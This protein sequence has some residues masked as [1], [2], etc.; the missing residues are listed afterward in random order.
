MTTPRTARANSA[1]Q[2]TQAD[3]LRET[4]IAE[5]G[6]LKAIRSDRVAAAFRAV[7]RGSTRP[8]TVTG[9]VDGRDHPLSA[10]RHRAVRA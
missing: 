9:T 10:G 6:E 5:L 7:P 1:H 8:T 3:A 2:P 4:V